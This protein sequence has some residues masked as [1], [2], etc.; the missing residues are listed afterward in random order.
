MG[1]VFTGIERLLGQSP[2][3]LKKGARVGLLVHPASVVCDLKH[4]AE[5]FV[6]AFPGSLK[7]LFGP[8]H[9]L[10]GEKQDNMVFS[11]HEAQTPWKVPAYSLYGNHLAPTQEML[12]GLDVFIVDLQD[13]GCRVYTYGATLLGCLKACAEKGLKV[14]VLDRPNP[15]GGRMVEG[16]VLD[17]A[18]ISFVGPHPIPMRH[19]LTLGELA[20]LFVDQLGLQVDLEVVPM[21]GWRRH[22]YFDETGLPWVLPSPNLPTLHSC[23]VYP[24][25][26]LLEGTN[27]SEGRGTTRPFEIF[28]APFIEPF[29]L[30]KRLDELQLPGVGFRALY[31]EPTHGKWAGKRC[32][33]IQIYVLDRN[34][35]RPYLT[36]LWII[37]LVRAL[38]NEALSW[39]QPPYEFET[40]RL[41]LDLLTGDP[42]IRQGL[43]QGL[44]PEELQARW[45]P[46]L[47]EWL[48]RRE[49]YLVYGN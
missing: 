33:G 10:W 24:G 34:N 25:Q 48:N 15:I 44:S 6:E 7:R 29:S 9:G 42:G 4:S 14:L 3:W 16:N 21:E 13:V 11:A 17:T 32:G 2:R 38:F 35:F 20:R 23:V 26:V 27:L 31:F 28:G 18:M 40:H 1:R 19:G 46:Q 8:Q 22:M 12:Q 5:A 43:E 36:S 37:Y 47:E 45:D 49:R 41:P 39:K 30:K